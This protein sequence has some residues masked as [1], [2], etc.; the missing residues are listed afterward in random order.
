MF[1]LKSDLGGG[2][3]TFVKGLALGL[4]SQDHVGSPTYTINR[5]YMCAN[6]LTLQHFDFYRLNEA[7]I[8]ANELSEVIDEPNTVTAIE[9]GDIVEAGLSARRVSITLERQASGEDTRI[10]RCTYPKEFSYLFK[11]KS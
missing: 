10:I 4:G 11:D 2:K 1:L 3:T 9:W 8:V 5:V 7:G 6:G